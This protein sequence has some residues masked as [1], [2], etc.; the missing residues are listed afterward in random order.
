MTI[1]HSVAPA[2]EMLESNFAR[3]NTLSVAFAHYSARPL[4]PRTATTASIRSIRQITVSQYAQSLRV[5]CFPK[6]Q[7]PR[8]VY[9]QGEIR[10]VETASRAV[11]AARNCAGIAP[12]RHVQLSMPLIFGRAVDRQEARSM[13]IF[14]KEQLRISCLYIVYGD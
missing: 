14:P 11:V 8:R 5:P 7:K 12:T 4:H 9:H 3:T 2:V 10:N 13:P 6:L 1:R